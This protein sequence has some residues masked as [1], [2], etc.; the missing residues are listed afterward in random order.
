MAWDSLQ[1]IELQKLAILKDLL[2]PF[3]ERTKVTESNTNSLY[4]L[5]LVVPALLVTCLSSPEH[6]P[7]AKDAALLAQKMS[8][9]LVQPVTSHLAAATQQEPLWREVLFSS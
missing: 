3:A 9:S 6:M 2:L 7:R 5:S 8:V 1:P 4:P